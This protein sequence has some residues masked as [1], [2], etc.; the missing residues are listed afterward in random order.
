MIS[1]TRRGLFA[2]AASTAA[3]ATTASFG[4]AI[5]AP[6]AGKQVPGI[7]RHKVGGFEIT[8]VTDGLRVWELPDA[9]VQNAKKEE[10]NAV[11]AAN[12]LPPNQMV[13]P[14][15]PIVVNTGARLVLIDTG[16][17]SAAFAQSNGA[18]GQLASNL[19][20][21]G[22]DAK[23]I[24]AVVITHC[25]PDHINGLVGS[26]DKPAFPNAEVFVP[27]P[28]LK[29]WTDDGALSRAPERLKGNF[30]NTRRVFKALDNKMSPYDADTD[31]VAGIRSV[32][33]HGHT[34]GQM[35]LIVHSGDSKLFVQ[36]DVTNV[37]FLFA[38]NPG[39]HVMFD[40]DGPAA[41]TTRR[42]IY[43]MLFAEKMPM[44]GFHYVFPSLAYIEKRGSG[45]R[46]VP[47]L[48]RTT[49]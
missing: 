7:Y 47:M 36:A 19:H 46:E 26:D 21:C 11:L 29:F 38:R 33:T 13:T 39:W 40:M 35:S 48:W 30:S 14:F 20:A 10:V 2:G 42:K 12:F 5:A 18:M 49:L 23:A 4:P 17:G 41:E 25:H 37:P 45:Y 3:I 24:D 22:I 44:Q 1:T 8:V 31:V 16:L 43:D 15:N 27:S 28:E 32:A 6:P 9:F 34:P